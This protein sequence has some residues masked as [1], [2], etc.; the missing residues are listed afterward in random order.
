LDVD[1]VNVDGGIV[2]VGSSDSKLVGC[3]FDGRRVGL[4]KRLGFVGTCN[5]EGANVK[6][7]WS[8]GSEFT[9]GENVAVKLGGKM[10]G[11]DVVEE[12][13]VLLPIGVGCRDAAKGF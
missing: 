9:P 11:I 6:I 3:E 13:G 8:V 2:V 12:A 10:N 5:A 1:V 4:G 7:G